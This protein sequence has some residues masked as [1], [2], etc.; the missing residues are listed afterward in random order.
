MVHKTTV[1]GMIDHANSQTGMLYYSLVNMN[2]GV[3]HSKLCT[4]IL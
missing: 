3:L 4:D 2:Y 1:V